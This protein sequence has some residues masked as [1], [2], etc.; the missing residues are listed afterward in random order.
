MELWKDIKGYEGLYKVSSLGRVKRLNRIVTEH[1][2][3]IRHLKEKILKGGKYPNGY[4][5]ICLRKN[6]ENKNVMIHRLVAQSFISNSNNKLCVNHIDGNKSNNSVENLEWC[7]HSE[8]LK[9]A[10]NIGLIE[11]QC[12]I[13]RKVKVITPYNEI[14]NFTD[15]KECCSFFGFKKGWLQNRI[16]KHGLIFKYNEF[17]I[18]VFNRGGGK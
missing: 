8:N 2:G 10:V 18:E 5:F 11:N 17:K 14:I 4:K 6:N 16:R 15:M 12:K 1:T 7:T 9:H 3:N 13:M